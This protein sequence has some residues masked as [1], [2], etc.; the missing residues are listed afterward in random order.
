M[1]GEGL[2]MSPSYGVAFPAESPTPSS[3]DYKTDGMVSPGKETSVAE[4]PS[5]CLVGD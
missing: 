1:P 2:W 4:A 3:C 5:S